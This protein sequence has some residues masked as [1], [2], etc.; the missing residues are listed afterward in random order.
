MRNYRYVGGS[1]AVEVIIGGITYEVARGDI[2]ELSEA[3]APALEGHP[4]FAIF[5]EDN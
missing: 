5:E 1:A 3:E 2:L 4:D